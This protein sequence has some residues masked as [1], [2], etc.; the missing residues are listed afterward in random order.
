MKK[1][2]LFLILSILFCT[3]IFAEKIVLERKLTNHVQ[4]YY[5]KRWFDESG[6]VKIYANEFTSDN[7]KEKF[8]W[9]Y[10]IESN[11]LNKADNNETSTPKSFNSETESPLMYYIADG[12]FYI[13]YVWTNGYTSEGTTTHVFYDF[14]L[15]DGYGLY[16]MFAYATAV[17]SLLTYDNKI[18]F[19]E[20]YDTDGHNKF[21]TND[22]VP[23]F[24]FYTGNFPGYKEYSAAKFENNNKKESQK[25]R[26]IRIR[27]VKDMATKNSRTAGKL[28]ADNLK[29]K[30]LW[31][32][33][34]C[35]F[36]GDGTTLG[37]HGPNEGVITCW[38][39]PF[40][41]YGDLSRGLE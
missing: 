26:T 39:E 27:L 18:T 16:F 36:A 23:D 21:Y 34:S 35:M 38:Y 6:T 20:V 8:G 9:A 33:K 13:G 12:R 37:K 10:A 25:Y 3:N 11:M 30:G 22:S 1:L 31:K 29:S 15:E 2:I 4:R 41:E 7:G 24:S 40:Y 32:A 14:D 5:D 17:N 28:I 19:K